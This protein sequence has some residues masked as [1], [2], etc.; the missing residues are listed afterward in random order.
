MP[1]LGAG[2]DLAFLDLDEI[3]QV[4]VRSELGAAANARE[5]AN[6][7]PLP[8]LNVFDIAEGA[9][10]DIVADLHPSAEDDV[11]KDRNVAADFGVVREVDRRGILERHTGAHEIVAAELLELRLGP[12]ELRPV[13]DAHDI[14]FGRNG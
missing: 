12:G 14:A 4:H 9:D 2:A 3:A 1:G 13:V 11:G 7:R 5:G 8:D 6:A 10:L